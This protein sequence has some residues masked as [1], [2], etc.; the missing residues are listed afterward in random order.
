MTTKIYGFFNG[1]D[2]LRDGI[3]YAIDEYG[4]I[5][6][7][8]FCSNENFAFHDLGMDGSSKWKHDAYDKNH[9]DGWEVEFVWH[10]DMDQH[11]GLQKALR[12]NDEKREPV[13]LPDGQIKSPPP[14]EEE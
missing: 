1:G 10:K 11:K 5:V 13:H 3:A 14:G 9:S 8:H 6:G 12:L 7:T 4:K 2:P